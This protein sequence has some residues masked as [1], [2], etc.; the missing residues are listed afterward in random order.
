MRGASPP[1]N[2]SRTITVY[3]TAAVAGTY[4]NTLAAGAL[5]TNLGSNITATVATLIV[6]KTI[7]TPTPYPTPTYTPKP[8]PTPK[9][10]YTPRPTP[11]PTST[12]KATPT[13]KPKKGY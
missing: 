4:V 9:P 13:P 5:Q 12:P 2:S 10:T 3:V 8:T 6:S 11:K 7:A 1:A